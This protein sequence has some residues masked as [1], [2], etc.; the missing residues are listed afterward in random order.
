MGKLDVGASGFQ[1]PQSAFSLFFFFL[2][3]FLTRAEQMLKWKW[4]TPDGKH[5]REA[6]ECLWVL[7][8]TTFTAWIIQHKTV[9][10]ALEGAGLKSRCLSVSVHSLTFIHWALNCSFL[11][12]GDSSKTDRVPVITNLHMVASGKA[13][14]RRWPCKGGECF[15]EEEWPVQ[16]LRNGLELVGV[17]GRRQRWVLLK[18][19]NY[20]TLRFSNFSLWI[21]WPYSLVSGRILD[22]LKKKQALSSL[23]NGNTTNYTVDT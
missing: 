20:V 11:G 15:W 21:K 7:S 22:D 5:W 18:R 8:E 19:Y 1:S 4:E 2:M 23:H 12:L 14:W 3:H 10:P 6:L 16:R 13:S 9:L 17:W